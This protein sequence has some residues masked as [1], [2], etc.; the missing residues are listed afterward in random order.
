[1]MKDTSQ[2]RRSRRI[3]VAAVCLA[4]ATVLAG[5]RN[6]PA[7]GL[8]DVVQQASALA[9]KPFV[10]P[11]KIPDWLVKISYDDWRKLRFRPDKAWWRDRNL[12][13]EV[14]FFHPGLFYDHT[15]KINDVDADGVH[16][17]PFSPSM[18]DYGDSDF[19][20]KVPQDLGFAGFRLHY[21]IKRRDYKDEVIV[22]L[23]ATYFRAVG[24]DENFGAS[25]RGLAIDTAVDSGEEF[26]SFREFWLVRPT[27]DA[28]QVAIYALAD[29]PSMTGAFRF[30]VDPGVQTT[31]AVEAR[32][33]RRKPVTKLGI[34][35]LASMYFHGENSDRYFDDFRPEVHDSDG[36]LIQSATGEWIWRPL[37][38]P[39]RL[40][41]NQF[42]TGGVQGFGLIQRDRD[43]TH[44]QDLET[45]QE[46]RP[47]IWVV[48]KSDW[49]AGHVELVEIPTTNDY[50][51]NIVAYWVPTVAKDAADPLSYSYVTYWYG[52]DPSRPPDGRAVATRRESGS[53]KGYDR[54]VVDFD[55]PRLQKL[56]ADTVLRGVVSVGDASKGKIVEQVVMK[57]QATGGW[58]LMFQV[59]PTGS[60]PVELRA[61]LDLGGDALTETW[62]YTLIP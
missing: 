59:A 51:D 11:K 53:E 52:D 1:M 25:A 4:A 54:F 60:A 15:V 19:A 32:L 10:A 36:L 27:R 62:T 40:A 2:S 5:P 20:S 16:P 44:Y 41:V 14:Q 22:F 57:N 50:N 35:P 33:F 8:D 34:A 45:R 26:P 56:D 17:I 18:F 21:P 39:V 13:F 49:G 55:G 12:P 7:F 48:P 23:G 46:S 58:R 61:F 9:A 47:S 6:A 3:A 24:R 38:N 28:K 29:S 43:F 37:Y 30:V 42:L 31:V